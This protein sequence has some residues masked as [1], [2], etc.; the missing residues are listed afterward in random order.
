MDR[1]ERV[2][3]YVL[4][5]FGKLFETGWVALYRHLC[6]V[7]VYGRTAEHTVQEFFVEQI[8]L[9]SP[10]YQ[11]QLEIN[12]LRPPGGRTGPVLLRGIHHL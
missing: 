11:I 10:Y 6:K 12:C 7:D 2:V 5:H 9:E 8:D 1:T 4:N 3:R